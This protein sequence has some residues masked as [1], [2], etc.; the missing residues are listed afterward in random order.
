MRIEVGIELGFGFGIGIRDIIV[1]GFCLLMSFGWLGIWV[2][3]SNVFE[4]L[5]T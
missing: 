1:L 5:S 3:I 2:L 4:V